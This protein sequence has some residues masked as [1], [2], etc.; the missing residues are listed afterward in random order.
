MV[1]VWESLKRKHNIL[2]LAGDSEMHLF[3]L[4]RGPS[5]GCRRAL[6]SFRAPLTHTA[7]ITRTSQVLCQANANQGGLVFDKGKTSKKLGL[8]E[9]LFIHVLRTEV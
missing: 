4:Q 3:S 9:S 1:C 8:S 7:H 2:P 6:R 5:P